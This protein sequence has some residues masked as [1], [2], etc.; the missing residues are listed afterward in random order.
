MSET[1][2]VVHLIDDDPMVRESLEQVLKA[3]GYRTSAHGS[4]EEFLQAL[5]GLLPGCL[6]LD[7]RLPGMNGLELQRE[8]QRR[9]AV[10]QVIVVSGH[11]DVPLAVQA[12]RA[13]AIDIIE[14]PYDLAR[15]RQSLDAAMVSQQRELQ[16][17][18]AADRLTRLS[19]REREVLA[20]L[21]DGLSNK[22]I[23]HQLGISMRTVEVHRAHVMEKL[24]AASLAET[25]RL[26]LTGGFA[27]EPR[28]AG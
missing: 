24:G 8:L 28:P 4:A 12:M 25:L 6:V 7:I 26:A 16:V 15:L 5:P 23:A 17:K 19:P 9:N 11:A 27:P 20:G 1:P 14:K 3:L 13:G 2:A 18:T 22:L 10:F 21:M